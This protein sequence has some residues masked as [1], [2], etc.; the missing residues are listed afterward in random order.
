M[1]HIGVTPITFPTAVTITPVSDQIVVKGIKGEL[2]LTLPKHISV[3][4]DNQQLLVKCNRHD[5]KTKALHGLIRSLLNNMVTGVD[6]G[7]VKKLELVGTG[8][9]A[10]TESN[11]LI[12]SLGFSHPVTYTPPPGV[13]L[14]VE[15]DTV[16]TVSGIDRQQVGQVAADIR[17]FRPP[18]P[19][20]GKGVR[21]QGEVIRRKAGKAAK[22]GSAVK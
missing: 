15:G 11:Q 3:N 1:S 19:Y 17:A 10:K 12:L 7:F 14:T 5:L 13:Q 16:V 8:Y 18:E 2:T 22:V 21:Y 9:R 4:I 20:K 6:Q